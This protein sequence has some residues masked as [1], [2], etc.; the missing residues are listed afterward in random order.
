MNYPHHVTIYDFEENACSRPLRPEE[1]GHNIGYE[2]FEDRPILTFVGV[3]GRFGLTRAL[4]QKANDNFCR[5]IS[6]PESIRIKAKFLFIPEV[7][8]LYLT[9]RM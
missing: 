9:Q 2:V 1:H 3:F 7:K 8:R 4:R 5:S 6:R